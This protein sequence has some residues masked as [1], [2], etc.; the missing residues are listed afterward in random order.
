MPQAIIMLLVFMVLYA[1]TSNSLG[2]LRVELKE[3]NAKQALG[4]E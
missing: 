3:C 4:K 2:E 1:I